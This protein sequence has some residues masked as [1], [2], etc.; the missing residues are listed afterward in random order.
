MAP[1]RL[2]IALQQGLVAGVQ[3]D[4]VGF[5]ALAAQLPQ[6]VGQHVEVL[7]V[8][9]RVD[10]DREVHG[11]P[12]GAPHFIDG[13]DQQARG[14]VVDAVVAEVFEDV[15]GDGLPRTG[16]SA[17]DDQAQFALHASSAPSMSAS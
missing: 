16:E 5:D 4:D 2:P 6:Q 17:D 14:Q 10:A 11:R 3:E 9:A 7:R 12:A 8:V 15:K 13:R 1:P